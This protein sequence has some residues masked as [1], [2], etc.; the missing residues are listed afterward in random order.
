MAH[1]DVVRR[2]MGKKEWI[3]LQYEWLKRKIISEKVEI[4]GWMIREARQT[5]EMQYEFYDD[6]YRTLSNGD[7]IFTPDGTA[8]LKVKTSLPKELSDKNVWFYLKTSSE[9]IVKVNGKWAGGLDPNRDRISISEYA[10]ENGELLIEIEGYNRSKPDDERNPEVMRLKGCRQVFGGAYF[11]T[12]NNEVLD[13][14]YDIGVLLDIAEK[15]SFNDDYREMVVERLYKA[16]NMLD[17][18]EENLAIYTSQV[19]NM[20]KYI[21]DNIFADRKY[22]GDGN[23]ALVAH[24][25]LDL[26]YY[27]R[28]IHSV[29][30]NARTCLIQLRL[31]D[32]YPEFLYAHSQAYTYEML[33]KHYPD[34]F[35]EV[36]KRVKEGR[37]EPV[38]A[39]YVE[40][41]CNVPNVESLIRQCLY[42]QK[43]FQARFGLKIKNCWLPDVFGNS[44][45][46]PQILKKSGVDYFVSNKMSTWNDTNR[47]PYNNFIWRGIDG[48]E[49]Y[50][51]VPP[52]HFISWNSP[53]QIVD[54]WNSYQDKNESEETLSMFGYGDGGSGATEQM[55]EYLKRF[56]NLSVMPKTR[57]I[58]AQNYLE[59]N[60]KDNSDLAVWDGELYLEMHRGTFTTKSD[61]K[62]MNRK[63]E[64]MLRNAEILSSMAYISGAGYPYEELTECYKL[65]L[66]NQFHDILPG[67]H[68]APVAKDAMSDYHNIEERLRQVINKAVTQMASDDTDAQIAVNTLP[69]RRSGIQLVGDKWQEI[70]IDSM[71]VKPLVECCN[72]QNKDWFKFENNVIETPVL[73]AVF[74]DDG[75][76]SSFYDK[77]LNRE[78]VRK[79]GSLNKLNIYKDNPG[80]YDAWDILREYREREDKIELCGDISVV[81]RNL[82]YVCIGLE[83]KTAHSSWKQ[84]IYFFYNTTKV[85]VKNEVDWNESNRLAKASFD[86]NVLTRFAKCDT[87]AGIMMREIHNNTSW[88]QAKFEIC[89]HKWSDL[90]EDGCGLAIINDGKYGMSFDGSLMALSLL[91]GTVR[92]DVY[93]D[94]G[95]HSF[96]YM[97]MPHSGSPE[98]ANVMQASWEFNVPVLI[99]K[100]N[101]ELKLMEVDSENIFVQTI[102]RAEDSEMLIVRIVEQNGRRGRAKI[103][104]NFSPK[105]VK[106]LNLIE[107]KIA[108][109]IFLEQ[110]NLIF[111]YLPYEIITIGIA[112]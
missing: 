23:V 101:D 52:T 95:Q 55:L 98:S 15:N 99:F 48:T 86:V 93:A 107:E 76:F 18:E 46:L 41:D 47:F 58:N 29:Q 35:E 25:H 37:F 3:K 67:S 87:S 39:M 44:W 21:S 89:Q 6:S 97:I 13:A 109:E 64:N 84:Y 92:P 22:Q 72:N 61:L 83:F 1:I 106:L 57:H 45:I 94:K 9:M 60:F 78:F 24:S 104:L 5:E 70:E 38:G 28:R 85:V 68:I 108:G 111:D 102:K 96:S 71:S 100:G 8:F 10:D 11:V 12:I 54:N 32:K 88:Q 30:K 7:L 77:T 73:K 42:G 110:N 69:F 36:V 14:V 112:L 16:F 65:L 34:I 20:R 105:D 82:L 40:P 90:S 103:S 62:K 19:F 50:A 56:D 91:R 75:S 33:E 2:S 17:Y 74:A 27:W 31:M 59:D 26:A 49:V 79:G 4:E 66:V 63:L 51:C 80:M 43:F 81:E 53:A